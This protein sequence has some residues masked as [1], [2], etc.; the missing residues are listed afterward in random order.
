MI[1]HK[2]DEL[3]NP[4]N[5]GCF[6]FTELFLWKYHVPLIWSLDIIFFLKKKK[7]SC[8]EDLE[9]S[10]FVSYNWNNYV[11][12]GCTAQELFQNTAAVFSHGRQEHQQN[13]NT[14]KALVLVTSISCGQR[15]FGSGWKPKSKKDGSQLHK[16]YKDLIKAFITTVVLR[17][18]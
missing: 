8:L 2:K 1:Y 15:P 16:T 11:R 9:I 14:G 10:D 7:L 13:V 17:N 4:H 18:N 6:A 5:Q 3:W 12:T